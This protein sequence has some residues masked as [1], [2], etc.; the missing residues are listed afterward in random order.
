MK[1]S[2]Q[3]KRSKHRSTWH[4]IK[5]VENGVVTNEYRLGESGLLLPGQVKRQARRT[6][7]PRERPLPTVRKRPCKT[8]CA[9][10]RTIPAEP[11]DPGPPVK[12]QAITPSGVITAGGYSSRPPDVTMSNEIPEI[13]RQATPDV[14]SSSIMELTCERRSEFTDDEGID[15]TLE[16]QD[17]E[18]LDIEADV[19]DLVSSSLFDQYEDF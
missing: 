9:V 6:L 4:V 11:P 16:S 5:I 14:G 12:R 18:F 19:I 13:S 1:S 2:K 8:R 15:S 3:R 7:L 17:L 10:L